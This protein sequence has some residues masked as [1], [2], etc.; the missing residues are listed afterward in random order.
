[1]GRFPKLTYPQ[2]AKDDVV[3]VLHGTRVPD[4]YRWLEDPDSAPTRAWVAAQQ[5]VTNQVLEQLPQRAAF[6]QRLTALW[7]HARQS[8]PIRRGKT[9]FTLRNDG[10]Q[11]QSVLYA[12]AT[13]TEVG[14]ILLDPNTLSGDGTIALQAWEPSPDG[15]LLAYALSSG[16]SDWMDWHVLDVATGKALP[17]VLAWSKF[18]GASWKRDGS[19]FFYSRYD[20]PAGRSME[21]IN[22]FHKLCFHQVG[23]TQETDPI[24]Y[25]RQDEKT[26]MFGGHVTQDGRWLVVTISRGTDP[27][28]A[29]LARDL[30]VAN[31]PLVPLRM[32]FDA[33]YSVITNVDGTLYVKTDLHAPRGRI[34][35][36]DATVPTPPEVPLVAQSTDTLTGVSRV[37]PTL[38]CTWLHHAHSKVTIHGLDGAQ[39]RQLELPGIGTVGGFDGH[40]DDPGTYYAFTSFTMPTTHFHLDTTSGATTHHWKPALDVD[41]SSFEVRQVFVDRPDGARIPMFICHKKG[42]ALDGKRPTYLYGYG[43]FSISL[44]PAFSV[45]NLTWM[46]QGGV[47]AV[48]N[49]RGGGEYGEDWHH[50]AILKDKQ[51]GFDDFVE[52]ARWLVSNRYTAPQHLGIGGGSNGGL[53]VGACLTQHPELFGAALPMVGVLDMLRF[54]TWTIGWAWVDDYGSADDAGMFPTLLAYSPLH[55]I[56][57]GTHYPPTMVMTADH[58]DRVVPAHSFKFGAALQA[59]QG[60]P[61][62]VVVRIETRAGHG[63]GKP[64]SKMIEEEA[65]KWAFLFQA[66]HP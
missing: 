25:A 28:N 65:D 37:G 20:P 47:Y 9:W 18:S 43:G 36:L 1:M 30:T 7:N 64:T 27:R 57:P 54:H 26:W 34:I 19:G 21:D 29:L 5:S 4:P 59:A 38:V 15:R 51:K 56:K 22:H 40:P 58:D 14:H 44:T 45:S 3:D 52:C 8:L 2:T 39:Q 46:E 12:A 23:T 49:I 61:A 60:G 33:E 17:D 42:L 35:T 16:G 55:N 41:A 31:A 32:D 13:P 24:I 6:K 10:L 66:L 63:A 48:A 50:A 11:N 62:P 53:L